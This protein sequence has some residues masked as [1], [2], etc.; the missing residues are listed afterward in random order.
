MA[1]RQQRRFRQLI[2]GALAA[3]ALLAL[4]ASHAVT[5][6]EQPSW[7]QL[8]EQQKQVLAPLGG[9][10]DSLEPERRLKWMGIAQRYPA[11]QA[12]EQE[13]IQKQMLNWVKL[14]PEERRNAREKY[15]SLKHASPEKREIIKQKWTEYQDLP[16][17]EK[18]RLKKQAASK[19]V[20]PPLNSATNPVIKPLSQ[21]PT[22]KL[23]P[24]AKVAAPALS[25]M[26]PEAA[27]PLGLST[28]ATPPSASG[29]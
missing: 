26:A 10:W 6:L 20:Q 28:P 13:R 1:R 12:S 16:E 7:A 19:K 17:E 22:L 29:K 27:L 21:R 3:G 24:G 8:S 11:M 4:P 5:P 9:E 15:K 25:A 23:A 2:G 14:S 18:Q